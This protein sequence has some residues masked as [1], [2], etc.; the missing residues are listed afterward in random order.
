LPELQLAEAALIVPAQVVG[1]GQAR[2]LLW[3]AGLVDFLQN[4]CGGADAAAAA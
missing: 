1:R 3:L 4:A 2:V